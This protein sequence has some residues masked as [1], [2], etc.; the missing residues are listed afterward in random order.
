[1]GL[2]RQRDAK[3]KQKKTHKLMQT[4]YV[5][6]SRCLAEERA[7][8]AGVPWEEKGGHLVARGSMGEGDGG[9]H[10]HMLKTPTTS[11]FQ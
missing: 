4:E 3:K 2:W 8:R 11:G 10:E 7:A 1:V 6:D 9:E 5:L